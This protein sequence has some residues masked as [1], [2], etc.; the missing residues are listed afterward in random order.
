MVDPMSGVAAVRGSRGA[1]GKAGLRRKGNRGGPLGQEGR[2]IRE[3]RANK[4]DEREICEYIF[5]FV[6]YCFWACVFC[7][8]FCAPLRGFRV[9]MCVLCVYLRF[10]PCYARVFQ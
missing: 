8:R 4:F 6:L 10:S 3:S 7:P 2:G 9:G 1:Y 5:F